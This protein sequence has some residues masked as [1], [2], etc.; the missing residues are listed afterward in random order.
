MDTLP[1][2]K[3]V[4]LDIWYPALFASHVGFNLSEWEMERTFAAQGSVLAR[5]SS[6]QA[7]WN[8]RHLPHSTACGRIHEMQFAAASS[9]VAL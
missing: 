8:R 1:K 2:E 6:N 3:K 4:R 5:P 9:V 7:A